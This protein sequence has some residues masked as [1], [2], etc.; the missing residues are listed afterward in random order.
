[1]KYIILLL[2]FKYIFTSIP[3]AV[4]TAAGGENYINLVESFSLKSDSYS[5]KVKEIVDDKNIEN[6]KEAYAKFNREKVRD[7]FAYLP[8]IS[9]EEL[10]SITSSYKIYT[11]NAVSTDTQTCLKYTF[12]GFD[13][14]Y[15]K[16]HS[17]YLYIYNFLKIF[18][19][20]ILN[21]IEHFQE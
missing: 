8:N 20:S 11:L 13:T 5:L 14:C 2:L 15:S 19:Y 1:M 10:N 7:V 12:Y 21:S 4:I 16:Y 6:V 9:P 18:L 17:I 3:I